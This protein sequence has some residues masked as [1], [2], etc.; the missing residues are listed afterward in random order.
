MNPL[1]RNLAPK[2]PVAVVPRG[3]QRISVEQVYTIIEEAH[4]AGQHEESVIE[5]TSA[6][7]WVELHD[8]QPRSIATFNDTEL[9]T[10]ICGS[11]SGETDGSLAVLHVKSCR[12]LRRLGQGA[13][14]SVWLAE[15]R[16]SD[17]SHRHVAVKQLCL[18]EMMGAKQ[19]HRNGRELRTLLAL[20]QSST[21]GA[22]QPSRTSATQAAAAVAALPGRQLPPRLTGEDFCVQLLGACSKD[23]YLYLI[24]EPLLGGTLLEVLLRQ[25]IPTSTSEAAEAAEAVPTAT[26]TTIR[27][28]PIPV[29]RFYLACTLLAIASL[30]A[31]SI[32]YRDIK[33]DNVCVHHED[34]YPRL[35]D[36]GFCRT[37]LPPSPPPPA[38][39][40]G[41]NGSGCS[42]CR[43]RHRS[44]AGDGQT[45]DTVA[46]AGTAVGGP[47]DDAGRRIA[48]AGDTPASWK[49]DA[50]RRLSELHCC[51]CPCFDGTAATSLQQAHLHT[52][53][54]PAESLVHMARLRMQQHQQ[55]SP[56][57]ATSPPSVSDDPRPYHRAR[58]SSHVG[59]TPYI[60][61]EISNQGAAVKVKPSIGRG[62]AKPAAVDA[63][64]PDPEISTPADVWSFGVLACE[65][66]TRVSPFTQQVVAQANDDGVGGYEGFN[67]ITVSRRAAQA[68]YSLP[69]WLAQACPA[70]AALVTSCLQP[71]PN[72]RPC[73]HQLMQHPFFTESLPSTACDGIEGYVADDA[74]ASLLCGSLDWQELVARR[75]QPPALRAP[76][77][78]SGSGSGQHSLFQRASRVPES[79]GDGTFNWDGGHDEAAG[80]GEGAKSNNADASDDAEDG[81]SAA[82]IAAVQA[83]DAESDALCWEFNAV[84]DVVG[85]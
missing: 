49:E 60:A 63:D 7:R 18:R 44:G 32:V 47:A 61:P 1:Y 59:S 85:R 52:Y 20:Q 71:H 10:P 46:I 79:F 51:S 6:H 55:A 40:D 84:G 30:H 56:R 53:H 36:F 34:G 54:N 69:P 74:H 26:T 22:P 48:N 43:H 39:A 42:Q 75:I 29:A 2:P 28:L 5:S 58:A 27:G 83:W 50:T 82:A 67:A 19:A 64:P 38:A 65:L 70:A 80:A 25:S 57:S 31:R 14:G 15:T 73:V 17:C 4:A 81:T 33:L 24:L 78:F 72:N 11:P 77:G 35:V 66:L 62:G 21:I 23:G 16:A 68:E 9:Y 8:Y 45:T 37:V 3:R 12:P 41:D 76:A 13:F